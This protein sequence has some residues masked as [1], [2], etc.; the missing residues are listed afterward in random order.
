MNQLVLASSSSYR[1][2][3]LERLNLPFECMAAEL[4]ESRRNN[5]SAQDL[6]LRLAT[7][8]AQAIASH[9]PD[10]VIIGSDQV[11]ELLLQPD[12]A[13]NPVLGK[14]GNHQQ[15]VAQLIAQSGRTVKFYTAIAVLNAS[16]IET[17]VDITEVRFRQLE[18]DEIERYLQADKPYDCAGSFKAES[19]G[20]S[21]FESVDSS[22]PTSLIGLPLIKLT[23]LLRKFTISIP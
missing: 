19:L 17:A 1:K 8:K 18:L 2:L 21:L 9:Y 4:D 10:A 22:D 14:P 7:E 12:S 11:A 23:Q 20:I 3:L 6:A 13:N 16:Q 15:A 5:E